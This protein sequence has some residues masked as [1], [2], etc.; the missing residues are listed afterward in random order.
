MNRENKQTDYV[1]VLC[2]C[3]LLVKYG[4]LEMNDF[5]DIVES[6]RVAE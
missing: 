4:E 6:W 3:V 1:C 5:V 2:E